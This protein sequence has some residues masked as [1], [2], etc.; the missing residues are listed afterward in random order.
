MHRDAA[1]PLKKGPTL[2]PYDITM[3]DRTVQPTEEGAHRETDRGG[4]AL[5]KV[6]ERQCTVQPTGRERESGKELNEG[7]DLAT[8]TNA[9]GVNA[10]RWKV[11]WAVANNACIVAKSVA[12]SVHSGA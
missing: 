2:A 5:S 1:K 4:S 10:L 7:S 8:A 3:T 6:L 9:S 11:E 12:A